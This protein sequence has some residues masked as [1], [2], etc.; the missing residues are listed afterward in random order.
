MLLAF[1]PPASLRWTNRTIRTTRP[2][3]ENNAKLLRLLKDVPAEK[4]TARFRCVIALTPLPVAQESSASPVC[5]ADEAEMQTENFDGTCEGR[6]IVTPEW[7][8]RFW[9]RPNVCSGRLRT[10]V[11]RT[12]RAGQEP[13]SHRA[14]ALAKL[15]ARLEQR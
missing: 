10:V 3:A 7:P 11:R 14:K 4:R 12:G 5:Y 6:I 8:R 15:R 13:L 1:I 9:L 2:T